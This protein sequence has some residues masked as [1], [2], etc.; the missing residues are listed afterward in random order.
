MV[1]S[2]ENPWE[3]P[4][5]RLLSVKGSKMAKW[6]KIDHQGK[7]HKKLLKIATLW[8]FFFQVAMMKSGTVHPSQW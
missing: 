4:T 8:L 1:G 3:A 5:S 6:A 7:K 2:S